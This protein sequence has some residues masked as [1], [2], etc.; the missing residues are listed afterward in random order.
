[1]RKTDWISWSTSTITQSPWRPKPK[2]SLL[3][4]EEAGKSENVE[5]W[6]TIGLWSD[7]ARD[8]KQKQTRTVNDVK[9]REI[10]CITCT[11]SGTQFWEFCILGLTGNYFCWT[12]GY[13]LWNGVP[14]TGWQYCWKPILGFSWGY[15]KKTMENWHVDN[16]DSPL[17]TVSQNPASSHSSSSAYSSNCSISTTIPFQFFSTW[18]NTCFSFMLTVLKLQTEVTLTYSVRCPLSYI[19]VALDCPKPRVTLHLSAI[20]VRPASESCFTL[21]SLEIRR[22]CGDHMK[23]I[24]WETS[25][26]PL[27]TQNQVFHW[28]SSRERTPHGPLHCARSP[29][30]G[31]WEYMTGQTCQPS[32]PNLSVPGGR[33]RNLRHRCAMFAFQ[34]PITCIPPPSSVNASHRKPRYRWSRFLASQ[35]AVLWL[36]CLLPS[37]KHSVYQREPSFGVQMRGKGGLIGYLL[38]TMY[39]WDRK[40]K[41]IS[42][43]F[44]DIDFGIWIFL[45]LLSAQCCF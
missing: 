1:M 31:S 21:A 11:G 15:W 19:A 2:R 14:S 16:I 45:L 44:K 7:I 12:G 25:H 42:A 32:F 37:A 9:G 3:I 33:H 6:W 41:S 35:R 28:N 18:Q 29:E 36:L 5:A 13:Q 27:D 30:P 39:V 10:S 4:W 26:P 38:C 8:N 17:P 40:D 20:R 24:Q 22:P 23:I 43:A 34:T